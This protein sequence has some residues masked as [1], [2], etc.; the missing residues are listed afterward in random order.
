M[1]QVKLV[2]RQKAVSSFMVLLS[3]KV[4]LSGDDSKAWTEN[5]GTDARSLQG[6]L[7]P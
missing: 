4:G 6:F 7:N 5:G 2:K 3:Q 1:K